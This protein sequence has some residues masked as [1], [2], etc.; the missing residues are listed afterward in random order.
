M[1]CRACSASSPARCGCCA[2]SR[3]ASSFPSRTSIPCSSGSTASARRRQPELR[4]FVAG[5]FAHRRKALARSLSL[6]VGADRERVRHALE[7]LGHRADARAEQLAPRSSKRC[8]GRCEG[9]RPA[10]INLCLLVGPLRADGRHELVSVM[11][12]DHGLRRAR[13][14]RRAARRGA[15]PRRRGA[16]P[17]GGGARRLPRR[18]RMGRAR[19]SAS[20]SSRGSRSPPGSPAARRTQRR[21]LRLCSRRSGLGDPDALRADRDRPG[22]RRARARRAADRARPRGRRAGR[23]D[24]ARAVRRPRRPLARAPL[25]RGG[26]RAGRPPREHAPRARGL[27]PLAQF[28]VNDLQAAAIALEPSIAP[29]LAAVRE[30]GAEHALVCGSG[31]TVI[32][33]F[34]SAPDALRR[35]GAR[36]R[37]RAREAVAA[38]P[39][40][41]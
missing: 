26:V 35:A 41:D 1:A 31:P 18:H 8:G 40:E 3:A 7:E 22:L 15:L 20:R 14:A 32:G 13:D 19:A 23:A 6:S 39:Y 28:G 5:A 33:L 38:V 4:R 30:A 17:R 34:A 29:A 10:K 36:G 25:D 21:S 12:P 16:Q 37:K 27:D 11:A 9:A 2:R 24:R